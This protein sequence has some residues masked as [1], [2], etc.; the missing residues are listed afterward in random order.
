MDTQR[1]NNLLSQ[2]E[3]LLSELKELSPQPNTTWP[4]L[5]LAGTFK[6]RSSRAHSTPAPAAPRARVIAPPICL[7]AAAPVAPTW[8]PAVG[9]ASSYGETA[10]AVGPAAP[11]INA[12]PGHSVAATSAATYVVAAGPTK[13]Q[14]DDFVMAACQEALQKARA[15]LE[16]TIQQLAQFDS[17]GD[18]GRRAMLELL[19][20]QDFL[21][22]EPDPQNLVEAVI[23]ADRAEKASPQ[24]TR[25]KHVTKDDIVKVRDTYVWFTYK[26][27]SIQCPDQFKTWVQTQFKD[28]W[29]GTLESQ[30]G[31]ALSQ[32]PTS[33]LTND[34]WKSRNRKKNDG[35]NDGGRPRR[36][37]H[38]TNSFEASPADPVVQGC[39]TRTPWKVSI[40][41][42][43]AEPLVGPNDE[44]STTPPQ[45]QGWNPLTTCAV[46]NGGVELTNGGG[47]GPPSSPTTPEV[48]TQPAWAASANQTLREVIRLLQELAH[49]MSNINTVLHG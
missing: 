35:R 3:L 38:G 34:A 21:N 23:H 46:I 18:Y 32:G 31:L 4:E 27:P 42:V 19:V 37:G 24:G 2:F 45:A 13:P 1:F 11:P 8:G 5:G 12:Y 22:K 44:P 25:A 43:T 20:A 49:Q 30:L 7:Q 9:P 48:P 26:E 14:S 28:K 41:G 33:G 40:D 17:E 15:M 29:T 47:C 6:P 16:S 39:D 36:K 10:A